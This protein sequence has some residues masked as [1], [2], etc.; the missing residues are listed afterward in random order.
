MSYMEILKLAVAFVIL[1]IIFEEKEK[2]WP[3]RISDFIFICIVFFVAKILPGYWFFVGLIFV[4]TILLGIDYILFSKKKDSL[5]EY[6]GAFVIL[7][8]FMSFIKIL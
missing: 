1:Y 4:P 2:S 7:V 3:K 6:A 5:K 8:F